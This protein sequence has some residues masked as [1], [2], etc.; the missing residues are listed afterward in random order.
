MR[1]SRILLAL[2]FCVLPSCSEELAQ[3]REELK[4]KESFLGVIRLEIN[5]YISDERK[6]ENLYET[7]IYQKVVQKKD[8]NNCIEKF[9]KILLDHGYSRSSALRV[10]N[11]VLFGIQKNAPVWIVNTK[12]NPLDNSNRIINFP[13]SLLML[14]EISAQQA[15]KESR[16][17]DYPSVTRDFFGE[18]AG[19]AL[20]KINHEDLKVRTRCQSP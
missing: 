4:K 3:C 11:D 20:K 5:K 19:D 14:E 8:D 12:F 6:L 2:A 17:F 1:H 15:K 18:D 16:E 9:V 10:L 7:R 13:Y